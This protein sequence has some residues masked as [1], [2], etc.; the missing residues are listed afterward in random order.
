MR[1]NH[2]LRG[3]WVG[4]VFCVSL[5]SSAYA[6]DTYRLA[7]KSAVGDVAQV[8]E[9]LSMDVTMKPAAGLTTVPTLHT[10]MQ[11]TKKYQQSVLSKNGNGEFDSLSRTYT[12][13]RSVNK[14]DKGQKVS[15]SPLLGKTVLI[16]RKGKEVVVT[17]TDGTLP[18]DV[19][20]SLQEALKE[21]FNF[22]P[23]HAVAV[24]DEWEIDPQKIRRSA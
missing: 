11:E 20:S 2:V 17:G 22:V 13:M 21:V 16:Q 23:D 9:E 15:T 14:N 10:G 1:R 7:D 5:V 8:E 24:G 3:G 12:A 4:L 6:Q 19:R 18:L